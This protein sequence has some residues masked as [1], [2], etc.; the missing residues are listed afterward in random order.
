MTNDQLPTSEQ[1][2]HSHYYHSFF[3]GY[4]ES[5][6]PSKNGRRMRIRRVYTEDYVV[7]DRSKAMEISARILN[8]VLLLLAGY[9]FMSAGKA[10]A[11]YNN[12]PVI[13]A[14]SMM[15]MVSMIIT[16]GVTLMYFIRPFKMTEYD[17]RSTSVRLKWLA[18]F[19]G[20][21]G[22]IIFLFCVIYCLFYGTGIELT[23]LG[24]LF[25]AIIL[26]LCGLSERK[27]DYKTLPN[28]SAVPEDGNLIL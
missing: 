23:V 11:I 10:D 5:R 20:I 9:L 26:I 1:M 25:S 22:C 27:A 15:F 14:L 24:Y 4:T 2:H 16:F 8:F 28:D 17:Y 13:A 12:T 6:I 7:C 19:C 21:I 3:R 18:G